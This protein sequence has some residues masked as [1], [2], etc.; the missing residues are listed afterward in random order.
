VSSKKN[1]LS[2]GGGSKKF[3][4]KYS[5]QT[6]EDV[7]S[8]EKDIKTGVLSARVSDETRKGSADFAV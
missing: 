8:G 2:F 6:K 5:C 3:F 7:K 1:G 4:S